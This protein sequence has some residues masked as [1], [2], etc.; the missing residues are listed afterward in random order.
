MNFFEMDPKTTREM[1]RV[2][3]L[4]GICGICRGKIFSVEIV[5][6]SLREMCFLSFIQNLHDKLL[7]TLLKLLYNTLRKIP[8]LAMGEGGN[9]EQ[10]IEILGLAQ[11]FCN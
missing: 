1:K 9:P 8:A 4:Y 7:I 3:D 2:R 6:G 11:Q 10:K 5:R